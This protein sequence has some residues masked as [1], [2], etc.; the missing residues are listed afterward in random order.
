MKMLES[1]TIRLPRKDR[2]FENKF[3]NFLGQ[4]GIKKGDKITFQRSSD[5]YLPRTAF[6][7]SDCQ[8]A[9]AIFCSSTE[10]KVKI[11]NTTGQEKK[12]PLAYTPIK[13]GEFLERVKNLNFEFVDHIGFDIFWPRGA[14]PAIQQAREVL[15][16][17][18]LY[19][20]YPTGE[21][22]DFII[23]AT[24]EEIVSKALDYKAIRR[25]KFEIVSL[26]YTSTP[27]IQFDISVKENFDQI[28]G[29]FP[30]GYPDNYLKNVWVYIE[31]PYELFICVVIGHR[32][33][34][35]W[36]RFLKKGLIK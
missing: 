9:E 10:H 25:P 14:H 5:K 36:Y 17:E 16:K 26:D 27:I 35:D 32:N 28:K 20:L 23:P 7:F 3:L 19:Y 2:D 12:S 6:E 8:T 33:K 30:E 22:W 34:G 4:F 24:P 13:L 31:N 18:C 11:A 15:S 29:L 1:I 21:D